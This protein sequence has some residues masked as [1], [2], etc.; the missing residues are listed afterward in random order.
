VALSAASSIYP[1]I[2]VQSLAL[3]YKNELGESDKPISPCGI[4][5]QTLSEYEQRFGQTI[6]LVLGGNS[7]P[8]YVIARSLDLLPLG[9][10]LK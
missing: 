5:R 4:C 1:G 10:N 7:G 9:F 3:A 2:A 6:R 8:V